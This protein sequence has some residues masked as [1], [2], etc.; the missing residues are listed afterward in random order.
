V[1]HS[2]RHRSAY[3]LL[4]SLAAALAVLS[5]S[6]HDTS[7]NPIPSLTITT[8]SLPNGILGE[9]Y[10]TTLAATGGDGNYS[11]AV[12]SGSLPAGLSLSASGAITGTPTT[13]GDASFTVQVTSAGQTSTKS[14]A[15][16]ILAFY[17]APNGITIMCPDAAVAETGMVFGVGYTKRS[18][19]EIRAL[20]SAKDYTPLTTTCTSGVT[21]MSNMFRG[22]TAFNQDIGSW[23]VSG[24]TNMS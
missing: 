8:T 13:A 6:G 14:L 24:V 1:S 15:F 5:C 11:W 19:A 17:L 2:A 21:D 9:A 18:E 22:V 20:I 12:S 4:F 16:T 7:T 23:D 10:S 3:A